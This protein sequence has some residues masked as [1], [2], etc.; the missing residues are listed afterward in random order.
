[1]SDDCGVCSQAEEFLAALP[2]SSAG[3]TSGTQSASKVRLRPARAKV[4]RRAAFLGAALRDSA[5]RTET[6]DRGIGSPWKPGWYQAMS[7]Q[8]QGLVGPNLRP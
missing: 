4:K 3:G 8:C 5:M 2:S 1:M 6:L 7:T